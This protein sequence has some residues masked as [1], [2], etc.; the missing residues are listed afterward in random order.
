MADPKVG[1][2]SAV[3]AQ[4]MSYKDDA[5]T[6]SGDEFMST[7]NKMDVEYNLPITS[8]RNAK[9]WYAHTLIVAHHQPP[10]VAWLVCSLVCFVLVPRLQPEQYPSCHR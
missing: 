7:R 6:H 9:W 4:D 5:P 1:D 3:P 10:I 2:G 8:N